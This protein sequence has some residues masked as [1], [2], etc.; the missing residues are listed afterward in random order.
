MKSTYLPLRLLR[1]VERTC[2]AFGID[3]DALANLP[4]RLPSNARKLALAIYFSLP[5]EVRRIDPEAARALIFSAVQDHCDHLRDD[6]Q[7][8]V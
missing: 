2:A 8:A 3:G 7:H 6:D 5:A 1:A 4:D